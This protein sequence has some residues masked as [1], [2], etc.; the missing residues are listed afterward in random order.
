MFD[1]DVVLG[2]GFP[3]VC[4]DPGQTEFNLIHQILVEYFQCIRPWGDR[5]LG[6]SLKGT[7][8]DTSGQTQIHAFLCHVP[9]PTPPAALLLSEGNSETSLPFGLTS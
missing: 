4:L 6:H 9:V 3:R 2:M 1:A 5:K 7:Q 8:H